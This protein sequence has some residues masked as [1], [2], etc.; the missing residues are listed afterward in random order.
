MH[1]RLSIHCLLTISEDRDRIWEHPIAYAIHMMHFCLLLETTSW[2]ALSWRPHEL[3]AFRI[4]SDISWSKKISSVKDCFCWKIKQ[5]QVTVDALLAC[6]RKPRV[7]SR[8]ASNQV[9]RMKQWSCCQ[10]VLQ[11]Q[12]TSKKKMRFNQEDDR[13]WGEWTWLCRWS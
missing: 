10:I 13:F 4:R 5:F 3:L 8:P 7:S 12:V 6:V 2:R 9:A 11:L 1:V